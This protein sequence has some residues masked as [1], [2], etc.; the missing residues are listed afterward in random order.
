VPV[1][2]AQILLD[3]FAF[4]SN[5]RIPKG[6]GSTR[7][8]RVF[9]RFILRT[10]TTC[11]HAHRSSAAPPWKM[12]LGSRCP[13][14]KEPHGAKPIRKSTPNT[15]AKAFMEGTLH[16]PNNLA[17]P[18]QYITFLLFSTKPQV[19]K[20]HGSRKF[21]LRFPFKLFQNSPRTLILINLLDNS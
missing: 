7:G 14:K 5:L 13:R 21:V 12:L 10:A 20:I 3:S 8:W 15:Q 4:A 16:T 17:S 18:L 19:R 6:K 1:P 9:I 2:S 11:C